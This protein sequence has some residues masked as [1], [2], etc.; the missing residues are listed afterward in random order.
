MTSMPLRLGICG[1]AGRMGRTLIQACNE[2]DGC[3]LGAAIEHPTSSA[4]GAD[5]GLLAGL[6]AAGISIVSGVADVIDDFDVLIDFT[7]PAVTVYAESVLMNDDEE[8]AY[9]TM[10]AYCPSGPATVWLSYVPLPYGEVIFSFSP[11]VE[12]GAALPV[13][14]APFTYSNTF[15]GSTP[16]VAYSS[17]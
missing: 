15:T 13:I 3:V 10:N 17:R 9:G 11:T 1:A 5:A 16:W 4:L 7:A 2:A 6:D 8:V 12:P 14:L